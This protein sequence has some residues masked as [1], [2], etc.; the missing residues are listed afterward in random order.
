MTDPIQQMFEN[1]PTMVL[2]TVLHFLFI[3]LTSWPGI[4]LMLLLVAKW[5]ITKYQRFMR[6]LERMDQPRRGRHW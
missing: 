3:I 5:L 1:L 2:G 4:A 6:Q